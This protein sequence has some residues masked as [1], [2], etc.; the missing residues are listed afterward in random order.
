MQEIA[1]Q[2]KIVL[3]DYTPKLLWALGLF[4]LF[5]FAGHIMKRIL[6]RLARNR[7]PEQK[8]AVVFIA[9]ALRTTL[10]VIGLITAF[11]TLGVNVSAM[12]AGLG[13]TGFALG[14][15]LKDVLSNSLAG[16]K[17]LFYQP[18]RLNQ[19]IRI[20]NFQGTVTHVDLRY[21]ELA[22]EEGKILIPNAKI[23]TESLILVAQPE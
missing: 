9:K 2:M 4:L 21:T 12:V 6:I 16:V 19:T 23:F 17:I 7:L 18:F 3:V 5:W 1:E 15:A 8:Q 20:L 14:F 22:T 10:V 11:G 13:L